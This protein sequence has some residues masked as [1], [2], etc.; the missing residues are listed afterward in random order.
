[1]RKRLILLFAFAAALLGAATVTPTPASAA[2]IG[3]TGLYKDGCGNTHVWLNGQDL[4]P[5]Y[6]VCIPPDAAE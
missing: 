3:K 2:A 1:M 4:G 5:Q 6:V